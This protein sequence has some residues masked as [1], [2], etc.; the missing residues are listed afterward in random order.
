MGH[1][2]YYGMHQ[3]SQNKKFRMIHYRQ[4]DHLRHHD[5]FSFIIP[6]FE[7]VTADCLLGIESTVIKLAPL[8]SI[9]LFMAYSRDP[10]SPSLIID[11]WIT[12]FDTQ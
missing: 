5:S 7:T 12:G 8:S 9:K 2:H 10:S 3:M 1:L 4:L 6:D 11:D